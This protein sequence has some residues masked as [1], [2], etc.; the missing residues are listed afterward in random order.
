MHEVLVNRFGGLS[1]PRKSVVRLTDRPAMTLGVYRGR[2]QQCNNNLLSAKFCHKFSAL[3]EAEYA[4]ADIHIIRLICR[5]PSLPFSVSSGTYTVVP[6]L[7]I[8]EGTLFELSG[9]EIA[10]PVSLPILAS[11]KQNSYKYI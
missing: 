1:L 10:F 9:K 7:S 2:K 3:S 11:T 6:S 5:M 8:Q 4:Q